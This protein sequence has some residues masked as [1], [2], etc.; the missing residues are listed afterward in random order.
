MGLKSVTIIITF[1]TL[2]FSSTKLLAQTFPLSS[3]YMWN[4]QVEQPALTGQSD[5]IRLLGGYRHQWTNIE[6]APMTAY[7][8][9]DMKLPLKNSSA[10]IFLHYDKTGLMSSTQAK[11]SYSYAQPLT[12]NSVIS[13]GVHAGILS[14]G[15]NGSGITT[16]GGSGGN[17]DGALPVGRT[18]GL[19]PELGLGVAY[20][21]KNLYGGIFAHNILGSTATIQGQNA[22]LTTDFGRHFGMQVGGEIPVANEFTLDPTLLLRTDFINFQVDFST[23]VTYKERFSLGLGLRGYNKA[24]FESLITLIGIGVTKDLGIRYSYDINLSPLNLVNKGSH[25]LSIA[26]L[27]PKNA[28]SKKSKMLNHPRFL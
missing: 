19:R 8:G 28:P 25:E 15:I 1:L 14:T 22:S 6:G 18:S 5:G 10:G 9:A 7:A 4:P 13:I 24:S 12:Q 26:Y 23:K 3:H 17:D 16:P 20:K 11:I 27:I 2:G 21:N